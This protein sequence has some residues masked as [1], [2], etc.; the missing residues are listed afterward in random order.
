MASRKKISPKQS[1][2]KN[3]EEKDPI[4]ETKKRLELQQEALKKII[5]KFSQNINNK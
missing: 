1:N 5:E 4:S 2:K 3:E